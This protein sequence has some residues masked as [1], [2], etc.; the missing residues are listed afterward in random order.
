VPSVDIG[1]YNTCMHGCKYCY[2]SFS[3][4]ALLHNRQNYDAF[5]PLLCSKITE[6][7]VIRERKDAPSRTTLQPDLPFVSS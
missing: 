5:S 2:A 7:D 6:N 1:L 3:N 4:E